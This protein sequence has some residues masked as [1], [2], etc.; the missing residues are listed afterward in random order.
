MN[1]GEQEILVIDTHNIFNLGER[2][3]AG[4][5]APPGNGGMGVGTG[6]VELLGEGNQHRQRVA[7]VGGDFAFGQNLIAQAPDHNAGMIPVPLDKPGQVLLP[8][9]VKIRIERAGVLPRP[10]VTIL[11]HDHHAQFVAKIIKLRGLRIVRGAD[12][13]AARSQ[14]LL[15]DPLPH[16]IRHRGPARNQVV[17]NAHALQLHRNAIDGKTARGRILQL[18]DAERGDIVIGRR[19]AVQNPGVGVVAH[20]S[21]RR[22]EFAVGKR[23]RL[24]TTVG[25]VRLHREGCRDRLQRLAGFVVNRRFHSARLGG[26]EIVRQV[27]LHFDLRFGDA[28]HGGGDGSSPVRDVNLLVGGDQPDMAVNAGARIEVRPAAGQV[29]HKYGKH[30][31]ACGIQVRRQIAI[32]ADIPE[33]LVADLGAVQVNLRVLIN[34][35]KLHD[36]FLPGESRRKSEMF[37]VPADGAGVAVPRAHQ[38]DADVVG[39]AH[40][41]P[42]GVIESRGRLGGNFCG[43]RRGSLARAVGAARRVAARRGS[44]LDGLLLPV[45]VNPQLDAAFEIF[46]IKTLDLSRADIARGKKR[47][48]NEH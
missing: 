1:L 11:I 3:Q 40:R 35:V 8:D 5:V 20:R 14:Q 32:E 18:A 43:L 7:H 26:R 47:G 13:G 48:N 46:C 24:K 29:V 4:G 39:D 9:L 41:G 19:R 45:L 34:P 12:F 21:R 27:G 22:P 28:N 31:V 2:G 42:C 15:D 36:D 6:A 16:G 38:S 37:P 23:D 25:A 33:T 10:L 17:M 30:I 44:C